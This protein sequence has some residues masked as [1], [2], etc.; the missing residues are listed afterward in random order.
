MPHIMVAMLLM[1]VTRISGALQDIYEEK[2]V[3]KSLPRQLKWHESIHEY[4]EFN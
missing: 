2:F 3:S 1:N 4:E